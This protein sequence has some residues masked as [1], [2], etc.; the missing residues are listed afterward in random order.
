MKAFRIRGR[1]RMGPAWQPFS[2]EIAA[3]DEEGAREKLLSVLGSQHGVSRRYI[4]IA[5]VTEVGASDLTDP[6]V[7][8]ALEGHP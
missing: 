4:E 5:G 7:R 2:K 6:A 8:Y 3:P 1:F